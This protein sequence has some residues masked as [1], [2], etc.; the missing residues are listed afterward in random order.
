MKKKKDFPDKNKKKIPQLLHSRKIED[1]KPTTNT[2]LLGILEKSNVEGTQQKE[3]ELI[4]IMSVIC[5]Y[6]MNN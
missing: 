2:V 1:Q 4:E 3:A 6:S 5:S